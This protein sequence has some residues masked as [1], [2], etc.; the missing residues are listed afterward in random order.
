[1][2]PTLIGL[3]NLIAAVLFIMTKSDLSS[4]VTARRGT[5]LCMV[6]MILVVATTF[7]LPEVQSYYKIVTGMLLGAF[8]GTYIARRA[9]MTDLP[10]L[11]ALFNGFVGL[12]GVFVA[13]A[14]FLRSR[15]HR[16][17]ASRARSRRSTWS[18]SVCPR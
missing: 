1:M 16:A 15:H 3:S 8:I 9:K 2:S 5:I 6:G 11:I 10:Q 18:S 13:I 4:P 14:A 17:W 7:M 12:G